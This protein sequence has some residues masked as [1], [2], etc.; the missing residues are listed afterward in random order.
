[1]TRAPAR[2]VTTRHVAEMEALAAQGL[3]RQAI[4][5]A[6]GWPYGT[7]KR[8]VGDKVPPLP[9][10]Q[11]R[12]YPD[13]DRY[14]RMIMAVQGASYGEWDGIAKRFGL[15]NAR[16]LNVTLVRARRRVAEASRSTPSSA[17]RGRV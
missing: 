11:R 2:T 13:V 9:K 12:L 15:K 4:V 6:T 10:E 5:R 16:V 1:M 8:Y 14:R 3:C 17:D 7:V